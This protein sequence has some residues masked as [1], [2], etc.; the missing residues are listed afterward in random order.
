MP[1]VACARTIN[2][3]VYDGTNPEEIIAEMQKTWVGSYL[4]TDASPDHIVVRTDTAQNGGTQYTFY[5]GDGW[6]WIQG[7]GY[8]P[9]STLSDASAFQPLATFIADHAPV[10]NSVGVASVPTLGAGATTTTPVSITLSPAMTNDSY[11]A[12]GQLIGN[13][14]L[15]SN[16]EILSTNVIDENTVEVV[17]KNNGSSSLGG[18]KVLVNAVS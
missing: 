2:C 14:E 10:H 5:V 17:V 11:T 7:L 18:A 3:A 1:H 6:E 16:L 15:L 13:A 12:V 9:A 4:E 8:L